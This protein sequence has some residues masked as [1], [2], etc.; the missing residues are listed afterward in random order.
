MLAGAQRQPNESSLVCTAMKPF[1]RG[2]LHAGEIVQL[3][4]RIAQAVDI[5]DLSI[6]TSAPPATNQ[7]YVFRWTSSDED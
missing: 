5:M 6:L 4:G 2:D 3:S 1:R 7:T